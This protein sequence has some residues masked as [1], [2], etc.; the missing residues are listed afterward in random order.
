MII[1]F[2]RNNIAYLKCDQC[3]AEHVILKMKFGEYPFPIIDNEASIS[4]MA[5]FHA[6]HSLCK[7][8]GQQLT[9][10]STTLNTQKK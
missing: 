4:G 9:L 10:D 7:P 8:I 2:V 5:S 3:E 1:D 6:K